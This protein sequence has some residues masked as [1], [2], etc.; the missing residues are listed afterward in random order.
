MEE[1][2]KPTDYYEGFIILG[3]LNV[4]PTDFS[5][6]IASM[7]GFRHVLVHE[8]VAID[9]DEVHRNLQRLS[10]FHRF[11]QLVGD[12]MKGKRL[13]GKKLNNKV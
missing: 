2:L 8:Y 4:L 6:K 1:A 5:K 3:Q 13:D 11:G 9:W 7:A 10:D 12:W